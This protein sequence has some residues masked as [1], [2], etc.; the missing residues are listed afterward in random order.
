MNNEVKSLC[1]HAFSGE[2][3]ALVEENGRITSAIGPLHYLEAQQ[4]FADLVDHNAR[5]NDGTVDAQWASQQEW[6]PVESPTDDHAEA[7]ALLGQ[8]RE[9]RPDVALNVSRQ[10]EEDQDCWD[11]DGPHPG[12]EGLAAYLVTVTARRIKDGRLY[13]GHAYLGET[14]MRPDEP[15]GTAGGY[16]PQLIVEAVLV[17]D[18]A[19]LEGR[20]Q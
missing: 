16:L 7:E 19:V 1:R 5:R 13:E 17:C 6:V 9:Q 11:E 14:W 2:L 8:W 4:V 18:T 10:L 15:I 20:A 3:F 12:D